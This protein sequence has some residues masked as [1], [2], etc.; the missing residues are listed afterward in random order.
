M[1]LLKDVNGVEGDLVDAILIALMMSP[2]FFHLSKT[3]LALEQKVAELEQQKRTLD[4]HAIVSIADKDGTIIYVND[5]F[6]EIS[7]YPREELLGENHRLWKSGEHSP[8]FYSQ[9]WEDIS[10]GNTWHG[11][12]KNRRKDGSYYWVSATIVPFLDMAG[13]PYQ[14]VAIRTDIT[15]QKELE[16]SLKQAQ[17]VAKMGS[18]RLNAITGQLYWSDEIFK[19]F[20]VDQEQFEACL[21]AF[22][23]TVHP[24]DRQFVADQFQASM[25]HDLP[26][27]IEH[28]IV[29]KDTGEI[30]WVHERCVHQRDVHGNVICSDGTVQDI[31]ERKQA[32]EKIAHMAHHDGLTEL[33]NRALFSDRLGQAISS[34]HRNKSRIALMFIDLDKFKPINDTLGHGVGDLLLKAVAKRIQER[35]RETDTVGRI[36][37]D[38]FVVLLK[39]I[40]DENAAL[41]V[42]ES[43]R[44][45]LNQPFSLMAHSLNISASIGLAIYPEHGVNEQQ[46]TK[47][48]DIA[49]YQ[50]KHG[51]RD[52]VVAYRFGMEVKDRVISQQD[53]P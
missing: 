2:T 12:I 5:K 10:A 53:N 1:I 33:P 25:D 29:R 49:M 20:G 46:L 31:T 47:H 14:Y 28:R 34:A 52:Q 27:D 8:E 37:G 23:E 50:A 48:A 6:C 36:G 17:I 42:A 38:E 43:I 32:Q 41:I 3:K 16:G 13:K 45:A 15:N 39:D 26:Y 35:L 11:N 4:E 22:M 7:G 51:G 21:N 44:K 24:E 18:W 40:M 9:L 30:R 19:I